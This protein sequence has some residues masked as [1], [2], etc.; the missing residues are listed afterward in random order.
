MEAYAKQVIALD[1]SGQTIYAGIDVHL[2]SWR[3]SIQLEGIT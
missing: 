3:V 2:K 1:F